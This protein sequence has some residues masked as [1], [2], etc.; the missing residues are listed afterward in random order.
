[1]GAQAVDPF[2]EPFK[3]GWLV[4]PSHRRHTPELAWWTRRWATRRI[5]PYVLHNDPRTPYLT[6]AAGPYRVHALGLICDIRALDRTDA[7]VVG[8]LATALARGWDELYGAL[9]YTA[10]GHV[11][12]LERDGVHVILDTVGTF[13][14]CHGAIGRDT[15]VA[16]HPRL[17]AELTGAPRSDF[18][19]MWRAHPARDRGGRYMPGLLTAYE[20]VEI[21][22]PNQRFELASRTMTRFYPDRDQEERS[23]AEI[24]DAVVPA[25]TGQ[26]A[27]LARTHVLAV[28]LSGG[29]DS[30]LTLA[31]T[32]P[33]AEKAVYLTYDSPSRVHHHDMVV[34]R[35]IAR[36]LGLEH[37][38]FRI[39]GDVS[40]AFAPTWEL[41]TDGL[42]GSSDL[43][44]SLREHLPADSLHVKS[45]IVEIVRGFYLKGVYNQKVRTTIDGALLS[46]LFRLETRADF[47][48]IFEDYI[49][50]TAFT[51][52][53]M[54]G[55]HYTDLFYWE[56]L[57]P[58]WNG[59]TIRDHRF[60]VESYLVCN[61]RALLELMAARPLGDRVRARML[62]RLIEAMWP[63]LLDFEI[64]SGSRFFDLR[65][66]VPLPAVAAR[67]A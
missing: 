67:G 3:R 65:T 36:R 23:E 19:R 59:A 30:R 25:L 60:A 52:G 34:A 16:S 5:G 49:A 6:A 13:P 55:F 28:S 31:A 15:V 66:G 20:G 62:L 10:G 32:R 26:F 47:A 48:A 21:V 64:Y 27:R 8:A 42:R 1:M 54:R 44:W 18:A 39:E 37:A 38:T 29:L 45:Y 53:A 7:E 33:I 61:C 4:A 14:A 43:T 63:A 35:D 46:K 22:T 24:V 12:L 58:A 40:G 17:V 41:I 9:R 56:H 11:L 50:K 57:A 2:S 51:P